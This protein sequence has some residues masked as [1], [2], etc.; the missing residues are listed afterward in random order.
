LLA[1][2]QASNLASNLENELHRFYDAETLQALQ[3]HEPMELTSGKA[4]GMAVALLAKLQASNLASNLENELHRYY[5]AETLQAL[6]QNEPMELTSGKI[7][8]N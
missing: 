6:Q 2:L 4:E 1:K 3:Q 5:D 8:F 7:A